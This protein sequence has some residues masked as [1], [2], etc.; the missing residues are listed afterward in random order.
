[1][2]IKPIIEAQNRWWREPGVRSARHHPVRR[3]LQPR[4]LEHLGRD[5]NRALVILGPRQVGKTT[6]LEQVIDDLLD[7]GWPAANVTYFDFSDDR[8]VEEVTAREIVETS[9]VSVDGSL[10]RIFLLD[11]ISKAPRW[12]RW[13]K[14]AVDGRVGKIVATDSAASMLR[15]GSRESGQGR[16]DELHMEG[17]SFGEFLRIYSGDAGGL[18]ESTARNAVRHPEAV[19]R[20]LA[21]GGFPEHVLADDLPEVRRR[22]RSDI[23]ERAILRDLAARVENPRRVRDLF[24]YLMQESGGE[25]VSSHRADDLGA[26]RRSVEAW[27]ELLEETFLVQRLERRQAKASKRLRARPKLYAADHGLV[28]AFATSPDPVNDPE[29]R[30]KV[31][32]AAV[33]RHLREL[34]RQVSAP[35]TYLRIDDDL[36]VDFVVDVAAGPVAI[37]VTH[38]RRVKAEKV[39]RLEQ[40]GE[41]MGAVRGVMIHGGAL[42]ETPGSEGAGSVV[43]LPLSRFLAE[44]GQILSVEETNG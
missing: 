13:L 25:L 27:V 17:L 14:Q 19:E 36:E 40:A 3:D 44:P 42:E 7:E 37:E 35:M 29:V 15:A 4:V 1:M 24:V 5:E 18:S 32:E 8:L 11:E 28:T 33:Y 12:D 20:Y 38:S 34:A 41:V 31:F 23:V 16:W 9:P 10:P 6:L 26:D 39:A 30:A 43:Q 22:L 21:V 2:D